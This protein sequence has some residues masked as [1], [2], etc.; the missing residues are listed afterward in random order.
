M[1]DLLL[2][3]A[4]KTNKNTHLLLLA[5]NNTYAL[6]HA[7]AHLILFQKCYIRAAPYSHYL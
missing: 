6:N 5:Q 7:L 4:M 3:K 1:E 2:K